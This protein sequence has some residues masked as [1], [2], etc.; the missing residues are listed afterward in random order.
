MVDLF[1]TART[2]DW[3]RSV[4]GVHTERDAGGL[5][6]KGLVRGAGVDW[7]EG[8]GPRCRFRKRLAWRGKRR[9]WAVGGVGFAGRA[10]RVGIIG[11]CGLV[12]QS[13]GKAVGG[14]GGRGMTS[15]HCDYEDLGD[16]GLQASEIPELPALPFAELAMGIEDGVGTANFGTW[17]MGARPAKVVTAVHVPDQLPH[18]QQQQQ[19]HHV[20][21]AV[22]PQPPAAETQW[23]TP[24]TSISPQFSVTSSPERDGSDS[25]ESGCITPPKQ[26]PTGATTAAPRSSA[27]RKAD[28]STAATGAAEQP[29]VLGPMAYDAKTIEAQRQQ[30]LRRNREAA[31]QFRKRKKEYA[32]CLEADCN[33]LRQENMQLRAQLSTAT[34][35]NSMLREENNFYKNVVNGRAAGTVA[36][37]GG[38]APRVA[39]VSK[40]AGV[41]MCGLMMVAALVTN[42]PLQPS[43]AVSTT[44]AST[45]VATA[46]SRRRLMATNSSEQASPA[47]PLPGVV[48]NSTAMSDGNISVDVD[49]QKWLSL[50]QPRPDYGASGDG[51]AGAQAEWLGQLHSGYIQRDAAGDWSMDWDRL[52]SFGQLAAPRTRYIFCP[53]AQDLSAFAPPPGRRPRTDT[54]EVIQ[55]MDDE[56]VAAPKGNE[57]AT[58][59]DVHRLELEAA[60][61]QDRPSAQLAIAERVTMHPPDFEPEELEGP[62]D[63][64]WSAEQGFGVSLLIP[65]E[66]NGTTGD[67]SPVVQ[68]VEFRCEVANV[69]RHTFME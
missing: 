44:G 43:T 58:L 3:E 1:Q 29:M 69:T 65:T 62:E 64:D 26:L 7:G 55:L 17:G 63:Q 2:I 35:E 30:R 22:G 46:A 37:P 48:W 49:T 8:L 33:R 10:V 61:T 67:S 6:L 47:V 66:A 38:V 52:Q 15:D 36:A 20:G 31:Q 60:R 54:P 39:K 25:D 5:N 11:Q 23:A 59:D 16:L 28:G 12:E 32:S 9:S 51:H 18:E 14:G 53:D 40:V 24:P 4:N 50:L 34:Q 21:E 13:E 68:M 56:F 19:L 57:I 45:T 41:A 27:K 42:Q